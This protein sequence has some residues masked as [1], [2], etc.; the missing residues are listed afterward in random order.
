VSLLIADGEPLAQNLPIQLFLTRN[1][2]KAKLLPLEGD[3]MNEARIIAHF[4]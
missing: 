2:P 3:P 4:N 1:F